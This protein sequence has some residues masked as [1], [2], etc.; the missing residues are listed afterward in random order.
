MPSDSALYQT[1]RRRKEDTDSIISK[2]MEERGAEVPKQASNGQ[3]SAAEM[4][5]IMEEMK[6]S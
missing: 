1:G 5:K 4:T 2:L 6:E 3:P